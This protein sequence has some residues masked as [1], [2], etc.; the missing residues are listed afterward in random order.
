MNEKIQVKEVTIELEKANKRKKDLENLAEIRKTKLLE[1]EKTQRDLESKLCQRSNEV[2]ELKNK[3]GKEEEQRKLAEIKIKHLQG[4]LEEARNSIEA[5]NEFSGKMDDSKD[6]IEKEINTSINENAQARRKNL[7]KK[8]SEKQ[9]V[10][11]S[12]KK[13][14]KSKELA[15][16]MEKL[17]RHRLEKQLINEA[18]K[19]N[20][21][22]I[23]LQEQRNTAKDR[24]NELEK[25]LQE[26]KNSAKDLQNELEKKLQE[27]KDTAKDLENEL[28]KAAATEKQVLEEEV[29]DLCTQLE[30][31]NKRHNKRM[32]DIFL[33]E[34]KIEQLKHK[35]NIER[36]NKE[37]LVNVLSEE[38]KKLAQLNEQLQEKER[39]AAK[40]R[41]LKFFC[42]CC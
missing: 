25:K 8:R 4:L 37:K 42:C 26:Q 31:L 10:K 39:K 3:V 22:E 30:N 35:V 17:I 28:R 2:E 21:L 24:E 11:F 34:F 29:L 33:A 9:K 15:L 23:K 32:H 5:K 13:S 38:Q 19:C 7:Q 41:F 18:L 27:Q 16:Y 14:K 36:E 1:K 20:E 12:A 6:A 40:R